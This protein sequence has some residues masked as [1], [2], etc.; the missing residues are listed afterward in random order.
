MA[1][2]DDAAIAQGT[3]LHY[4]GYGQVGGL[5]VFKEVITHFSFSLGEGVAQDAE[6][7][8]KGTFLQRYFLALQSRFGAGHQT[9]RGRIP[10]H[11][12]D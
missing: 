12:F 10:V 11:R 7:K 4:L 1:K 9:V 5:R 8:W 6:T 3:V 2:P